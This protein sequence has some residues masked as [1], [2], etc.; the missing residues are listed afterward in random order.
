MK[1]FKKIMIP[2]QIAA[3]WIGVASA[4]AVVVDRCTFPESVAT[5]PN[6]T[7]LSDQWRSIGILFDVTQPSVNPIM[8]NSVFQYA[9][10]FS[11]L[12]NIE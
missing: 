8:E 7:V 2:I 1:V 12:I 9:I 5:V 3:L 10:C 6:V 4:Q 11:A